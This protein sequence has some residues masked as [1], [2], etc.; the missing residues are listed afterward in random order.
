M[1]RGRVWAELPWW[2]SQGRSTT[3][4]GEAELRRLGP[5]RLPL[6]AQLRPEEGMSEDIMASG[7]RGCPVDPSACWQEVKEERIR[8]L[9]EPAAHG[10]EAK[11]RGDSQLTTTDGGKQGC[12][13]QPGSQTPGGKPMHLCSPTQSQAA[14]ASPGRLPEPPVPTARGDGDCVCESKWGTEEATF[15]IS[16]GLFLALLLQSLWK[17]HVPGAVWKHDEFSKGGV[18]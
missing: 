3:G 16:A 15:S 14:S 11:G 2:D 6:W 12:P 5:G 13:A 18:Q 10:G 17:L 4:R 7:L 9:E 1:G 8:T